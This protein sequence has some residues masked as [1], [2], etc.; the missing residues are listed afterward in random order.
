MHT[1]VLGSSKP[2]R[3]WPCDLFPE[4]EGKDELSGISLFP[5]L[6]LAVGVVGESSPLG[7][8][9]NWQLSLVVSRS[10]L[11]GQ[12]AMGD[13]LPVPWGVWQAR[14]SHHGD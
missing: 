11:V 4:R 2:S 10:P 14:L 5:M 7:L 3:A 1:C 6:G 8:V 12:G 9:L 13:L